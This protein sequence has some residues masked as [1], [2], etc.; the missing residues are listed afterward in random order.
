MRS[1]CM[2]RARTAVMATFSV[3]AC[4]CWY[5]GPPRVYP[6]RPDPRA[7][8]VAIELF[9][10]NKDGFLDGQELERVPG[11]KAAVAQVDLDKDGKIAAAEISARIQA[12]AATKVGRMSLACVLTH[13]GKTVPGAH[14]KF[15]PEKFL[16]GELKTAEGTT[17]AFGVATLKTPNSGQS[18]RGIC[19]GFYRI[20]ITKEG[21][22]I[23]PKY[24]TETQL[25]QEAAIDGAGIANGAVK[26]D[27]RY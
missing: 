16:G 7:G 13:N 3:V 1:K 26:I 9:D 23:P 2:V 22:N 8:A 27:L 19:P 4:G 11:L 5:G 21:E 25:G 12:W 18:T 6:D 24:N 17:D 20:E 15:L 10:A 14:V